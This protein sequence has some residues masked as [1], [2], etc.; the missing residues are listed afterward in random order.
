MRLR[1]IITTRH[2]RDGFDG[3]MEPLFVIPA[4][5]HLFGHNFLRTKLEVEAHMVGFVK[6]VVDDIYAKKSGTTIRIVYDEL[7]E[8]T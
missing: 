7:V 1:C 3:R 6:A 5:S 8:M 2:S 4:E